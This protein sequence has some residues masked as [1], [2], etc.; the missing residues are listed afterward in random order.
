MTL[1]QLVI[2]IETDATA[3]VRLRAAR[4]LASL[5]AEIKKAY[6]KEFKA[7][8]GAAGAIGGIS[9]TV[10]VTNGGR[11]IEGKIALSDAVRYLRNLEFGERGTKGGPA[12]APF[13]R[14]LAPPI[15]NIMAWIRLANIKTPDY[16]KHRAEYFQKLARRKRQPKSFAENKDKP[17]YSQ[18]A[19]VLYA[20]DIMMKRKRLGRKGLHVIER[21]S[22]AFSEKIRLYLAGNA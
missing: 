11:S 10:E 15:K 8:H 6:A 13:T 21:T 17:W 2:Q 1:D 18:D 4:A 14:S 20:Y 19:D 5:A 16:Y 12:D 3:Q 9:S 22:N 7:S